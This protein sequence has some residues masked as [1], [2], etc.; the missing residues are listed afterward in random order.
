M[1]DATRDFFRQLEEHGPHPVL[2]RTS[3][4]IRIDLD[5]DGGTEHWRLGVHRGAVTLSRG[6]GPADVVIAGTGRAFDEV[7]SGRANGMASMLRGELAYEGDP[8][9]L[10]RF[11]R[12][13]PSPTGRR[14]AKSSRTVGRR[15]G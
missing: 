4:T 13:F 5:R 14:I 1:T 8:G 11:Q 7:A 9:L 2:Q 10:V 3:G 15:R 6:A 12:L